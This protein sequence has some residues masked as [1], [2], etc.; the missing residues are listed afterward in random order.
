MA[1]RI[2]QTILLIFLTV[3]FYGQAFFHYSVTLEPY[4]IPDLDGIHSY[5]HGQHAG[6]WV[7]I[8]GRLDGIHARQPFNAFP[9]SQNNTNI[10]VVDPITATVW[11]TPLNSLPTGLRE[12]LQSTNMQFYQ[13]GDLLIIIGGYA[14]SSSEGDHITF[15]NLTTVNVPSLI[16]DIINGNAIDGNFQQIT[17]D[18]FAVTGGYLG[19]IGEE[20]YLVGGHRFDG[21]YNPMNHATFVQTYTDAIRKF[22]LNN[23]NG[24][25]SFDNYT[26][27]SDPVHL[28]RRDYNL[29]PQVYLDGEIGYTIFSGVFQLNEDLPFLYPVDITA[30]GYEPVGS[31][32]QYLCN[33]HTAHAALFDEDANNMH[34]LFFGGIS[35]YYY[36]GSTMMQDDNVPFVKTISRVS[37]GA[38]GLLSEVRLP[39]EMPGYLGAGAELILNE[40]LPMVAPGIVDLSAI[41]ED[42]FLL[43]YIVGGIE[44][45]TQNPFSFNNTDVTSAATT[46]YKVQFSKT[47]ITPAGEVL[48]PGYHGFAISVF[49][50]PNDSNVFRIQVDAP[51]A[52]DVEIMLTDTSGNLILNESLEGLRQGK[53][54]LEIEMTSPIHGMTFLSVILNKKYSASVKVV[55]E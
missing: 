41:S 9:A 44:S 53:N 42:S 25:W 24:S 35:Q 46:I 19:K 13:D 7:I 55:F 47:D 48:L 39:I 27:I 20:F 23:I 33:Y 6:K 31:F 22:Q 28:H 5:A 51:E 17:D 29:L 37:R 2:F 18:V 12:Q 45:P 14:Y 43:G 40:T 54:E 11:S 50:N 52:G 32:N 4:S 8:G 30:D 3:S 36:S 1:T 49:P 15:P 21:R 26:V 34:N 10:Q 38:D 16:D